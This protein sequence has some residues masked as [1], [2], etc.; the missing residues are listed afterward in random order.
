MVMSNV[1]TQEDVWDQLVFVMDIPLADMEMMKKIV[2]RITY[3]LY[4][5]Q[6]HMCE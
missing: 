1:M 3:I 2:V 4:I 6:E 5:F